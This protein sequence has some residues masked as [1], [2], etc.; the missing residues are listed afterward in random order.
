MYCVFIIFAKTHFGF[1]NT[2]CHSYDLFESR[3]RYHLMAR[4]LHLCFSTISK[5]SKRFDFM[6]CCHSGWSNPLL[7]GFLYS[8]RRL[9]V[10]NAS[11][12]RHL[13]LGKKY[14]HRTQ[15]VRHISKI[16]CSEE[17]KCKRLRLSKSLTSSNR[18]RIT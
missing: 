9:R 17:N 7:I 12:V 11:V 10:Q 15:I 16:H 18:L 6:I 8:S 2:T 3:N 1:S 13:Y 14:A 5:L 4:V